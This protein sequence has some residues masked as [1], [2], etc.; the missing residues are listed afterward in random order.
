M[1]TEHKSY[2]DPIYT[3]RHCT[4]VPCVAGTAGTVAAKF[5]AFT[6]MRI[7]G[8]TASVDTA[9]TNTA[10]AYTISKG[11][12]SVAALTMG[13]NAAATALTNCLS[14][15]IELTAGQYITLTRIATNGGTMA[16]TVAIE[17]H[18]EP[19]TTVTK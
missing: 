8:I 1:A 6:A 3:A 11:T 7:K 10:A 9:G 14:A 13:T 17:W 19:L 4:I 18:L 5:P 12:T 16:A 15:D 2:D